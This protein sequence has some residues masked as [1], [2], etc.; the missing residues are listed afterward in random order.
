MKIVTFNIRCD[1]EQDGGNS[2]CFRKPLIL[3]KIRDEQPDV[4]CFQEVL[5]HVAAWLKEVLM[6]YTV[7]G[8]GRSKNL[9]D[10]Q[11]SV[12]FR[13]DAMNLIYMDTFWLSPTPGIPGSRYE[14]QSI[15]PRVCTEV[16]LEEMREEK[17]FR[18]FNI[19]LDHLGTEA[20]KLGLSQIL[21]KAEQ[22]VLF[23]EAPVVLAG[24][25]NAEQDSSEM[26]LMDE[27]PSYINAAAGIGVTYH[28][29]EAEDDPESIDDIFYQSPLRCERIEKWEDQEQGIWLSDHYPICATFSWQQENCGRCGC[30]N[31]HRHQ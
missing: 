3:K 25:F 6:D 14:E 17:I 28:G 11:V 10:E 15:C 12:A 26:K 31:I 22:T 18:L 27:Y 16:L 8:C 9:S 4:I 29:F 7:V 2:F 20:R 24:D 5:P 13:K 21:K 23:S 1:Y 19:H 30:R